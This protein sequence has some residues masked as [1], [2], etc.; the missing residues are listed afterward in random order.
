[1]TPRDRAR[2][3]GLASISIGA[4]FIVVW[5][6]ASSHPFYRLLLGILAIG[7]GLFN[8]RLSRS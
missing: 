5:A 6:T 3:V 4:A 8:L 1:M 7:L 2:I